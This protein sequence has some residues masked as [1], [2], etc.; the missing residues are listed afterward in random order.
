M[1]ARHGLARTLSRLGICSRS[2]ATELV[3]AGRVRV[4]GRLV[5]DPERATDAATQ[6]IS[7]DGA[8]IEI[9]PRVYLA[10]N[11]PR[12][13]VVSAA[14]EQGRDTVYSLLESAGLPW[15]APV[16]RLD[17]ASEG[18]LLM[19]NDSDWAAGIADPESKL[20]KTYHVQVRGVPDA[21][22]LESLVAGIDDAGERLAAVDARLLRTGEKNAW[23][24]IRLD[25]GR[26]R[27]IR[28][29]LGALGY[30]VV[31]LVR[32]AVGPLVLGTLAKGAWRPLE[33]GEVESLR[34]ER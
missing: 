12:G 30:T 27:E 15:V 10:L 2:R 31:R 14:D 7:V 3:L 18:L 24:E 25:E 32:I 23:L 19:T 26:N 5:R 29:L 16:G 20:I 13:L 1:A 17:K 34:V 11:K 4:D 22:A 33:T 28:R 6:K 8:E 21:A 9:P